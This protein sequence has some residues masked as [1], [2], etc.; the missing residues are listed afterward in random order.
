VSP[1]RIF[2]PTVR[3]TAEAIKQME[4]ELGLLDDE[5]YGREAR[6]AW[7]S[8]RATLH[9]RLKQ[10]FAGHGVA[11]S[12]GAELP[13]FKKYGQSIPSIIRSSVY[14]NPFLMPRNRP[15][16]F[17]S[18]V[19]RVKD[20]I[21]QYWNPA[22]D[23]IARVLNP[24]L[25]SNIEM[26]LAFT[27]RTP[28]P[29]PKDGY[30]DFPDLLAKALTFIMPKR[31]RNIRLQAR[32]VQRY[33][34]RK[35]N[36][37][38]EIEEELVSKHR[39]LV[40]SRIV[41]RALIRLLNPRIV[42]L[43]C[44]YGKEGI[45]LAAKD[46]NVPVVEFQHGTIT[47][48]HLGYAVPIKKSKR[49]APDYLLT[50]GDHWRKSVN[51]SQA[52]DDLVIIGF[53]Y[54]ELEYQ[55]HR[56]RKTNIDLLFVSQGT[57]GKELSKFAAHFSNLVQAHEKKFTIVYKLHPGEM[58][59][60]KERYPELVRAAEN[61][62]IT[63][64]DSPNAGNFYEFIGRSTNVVGVYSTGLFESI[65][66]GCR[67]FLVPLPGI[68]Y[69]DSIV[70]EGLAKVVGS[71]QELLEQ[72]SDRSAS[73]VKR[74]NSERLYAPDWEVKFR[75]FLSRLLDSGNGEQSASLQQTAIQQR[76]AAQK[77]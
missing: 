72:I 15:Y 19:G 47:N 66:F 29:N 76:R 64:V 60:W 37:N 68:E 48:E 52:S 23:P 36:V 65:R 49:S 34:V 12:Y 73:S 33:L 14:K 43:V 17:F 2:E 62:A 20:E 6:L 5:A 77:S 30:S 53:P 40:A 4:V 10:E 41:Y 32:G 69:M 8:Y 71:P 22:T 1:D 54:L 63:V 11:H 74:E 51:H 16:L 7:E 39:S 45:I 59:R 56:N 21:G 61:G 18:H 50:F 3:G 42:F 38:K 70:A 75:S 9:S 55:K 24:W 26:S 44:S 67:L 58:F 25:T 35:H 27:H 57:I 31:Y 28:T 13:R 46:N